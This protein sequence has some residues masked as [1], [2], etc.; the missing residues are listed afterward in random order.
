MSRS[1]AAAVVQ[2]LA[3]ADPGVLRLPSL[4]SG[5]L[6]VPP[7][8]PRD[9]LERHVAERVEPGDDG[10][11]DGVQ[12]VRTVDGRF[13]LLADP[14]PARL[15][16]HDHDALLA[17]V[18]DAPFTDTLDYIAALRATLLA[19]PELVTAFVDV[20]RDLAPRTSG[21]VEATYTMLAALLDP[22][23]I[24]R[25]VD[26]ELGD[27]LA[28]G[29]QYLDGW[30][31]QPFPSIAGIAT[32]AARRQGLGAVGEHGH[33][34][35]LRAMPTRQLHITAGNA[36]QVPFVALLWALASKGAAVIKSPADGLVGG[37]LL[38]TAM[39]VAAPDHPITRHTSVVH[40]AG[41]D[42]RY[43]QPL[44]A[45]GAVDRIVLWGGEE[46]VRTVSARAA[47]TRVLAFGPRFGMSMIGKAGLVDDESIATAARLAAVDVV[48][49][50]QQACMASLVHYVECPRDVAR[51]YCASLADVLAEWDDAMP[52]DRSAAQ[53]GQLKALRRG[54]LIS[55]TWFGN[56]SRTGAATTSG[57]SVVLTDDPFALAGHPL[58][59]FVV[60]RAVDD[61]DDVLPSVDRA[62]STVGVHPEPRR[63]ELRNRL[64]SRGVSNVLPLGSADARFLTMPH[65]DMR[66]LSELVNWVSG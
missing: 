6:V 24:A 63:L 66:V 42:P 2:S 25:H 17:T 33:E 43:E 30:V 37:A 22:D 14:G 29:R 56:G 38:A 16:Q 41:G 61:L 15:I 10:R 52:I 4:V 55:A 59:R 49:A 35:M 1:L 32:V 26:I 18:Y 31:A 21:I 7:S 39:H 3:A 36:A 44:F 57:S 58:S 20:G 28:A 40:W 65:D 12:V 8:I 46:T 45:P 5:E 11:L 34:P 48:I 62:V 60:V 9:V 51:R 50:N 64:V 19:N 13:I 53:R 47:G 27:G 54:Q 23:A